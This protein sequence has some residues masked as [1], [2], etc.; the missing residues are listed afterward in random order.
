MVTRHNTLSTLLRKKTRT[1]RVFTFALWL[2]FVTAC[3]DHT[4]IQWP[5]KVTSWGNLKDSDVQRIQASIHEVETRS[6][7]TWLA[8]DSNHHFEI[9]FSGVDFSPEYPNRAGFASTDWSTCKV[10]LSPRLFDSGTD[11]LL[12]TV[13]AHELGHCVGLTHAPTDGE[14]MSPAALPET[15]YTEDAWARFFSLFQSSITL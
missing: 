14:I 10:E 9:E 12:T 6:G 7:Q 8:H 13:V 4:P 1:L 11:A 2:I 15:M 5:A 3:A